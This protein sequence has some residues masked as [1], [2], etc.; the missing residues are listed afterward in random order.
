MPARSTRN[1]E[2]SP[3]N[4]F[5]KL[6]GSHRRTDSTSSAGSGVSPRI[7]P[8]NAPVSPFNSS[9]RGAAGG[10]SFP[11][12][13]E[14]LRV[15]FSGDLGVYDAAPPAAHHSRKGSSGGEAVFMAQKKSYRQSSSRQKKH[16]RQKSAQLFMEDVKGQE[17]TPACRDI[18]FLMIFAFHLLGIVY[19]G[20]TY[21]YEA[22][23]YH[24]DTNGDVT[25]FYSNIT[26]LASLGGLFAIV[27][28]ALALALMMAIAKKIVQV[29][30]VLAITL[31]FVWG[32]IGI[33]FSPRI[34]VPA[35]GFVALLLSVAYAFIVW[36]R[37]PFV[38][39][40]LDAGLHGIRSNLGLVTVAFLFQ[41][42]ALGWTIYYL[43]VVV[44]VYD[45]ILVGDIDLSTQES[46][47]CIYFGLG[48]SYYWTIHVLLVCF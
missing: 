18:F 39:S 25:I 13:P 42:L 27:I 11:L 4:E 1:P 9:L 34:L 44:G 26:Y 17:Q 28:S 40:N 41:A 16:M 5:I 15:S 24:Q 22:G 32:T 48:I 36:D 35:T 19:L 31:S 12:P 7:S 45:A 46:K 21:G 30:L 38:A 10:G 2:F 8:R 29:A 6:T 33:G 37:I 43:F 3:R 47:S 14:D 20:N 23:H